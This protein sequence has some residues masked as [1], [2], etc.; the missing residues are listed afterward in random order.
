[1]AQ[2]VK[3]RNA[4]AANDSGNP[5][6]ETGIDVDGIKEVAVSIKLGGTSPTWDVTPIFWND[7]D[8]ADRF[9]DDQTKTVTEDVVYR[10]KVGSS[11]RMYFRVDGKTG[12]NPTITIWVKIIA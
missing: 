8:D 6:V 11:R 5:T 9:F 4:V 3:V 12:T 10:L 2:W 1:M 7:H